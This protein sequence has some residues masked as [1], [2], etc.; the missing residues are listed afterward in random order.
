MNYINSPHLQRLYQAE[1]GLKWGLSKFLALEGLII[2]TMVAILK[3][4]SPNNTLSE[5]EYASSLERKS[6]FLRILVFGWITL[7]LLA[8]II[9]ITPPVALWDQFVL[10]GLSL[11][12]SVGI[13][14][15]NRRK[16]TQLAAT[17][18]CIITNLILI[19]VFII[20]VYRDGESV[21]TAILGCLLSLGILFAGM[22]IDLKFIFWSAAVNIG[23]VLLAFQLSTELLVEGLNRSFPIAVFLTIIALTSW[24]YQ[25]T[26]NQALG[27]LTAAR[28]AAAQAKVLQREVEIARDLQ[29]RLYP[30]PPDY[31]GRIRFAARSEPA[32][33]TGGDFYDFISLEDDHLGIVVADVSGKSFSAALVMAMARSIIR[34]GAML[35]LSPGEVLR[36]TN[37]SANQDTSVDQ[38]ITVFYGVLNTRTLRFSYSNAGHPYPMLKRDNTIK[39][40]DVPGFPIKSFPDTHYHDYS[41][42]LQPGDQLLW[43]SDGVIET[44]NQHR[45]LFGF[46]RLENTFQQTDSRDPDTILSHMWQTLVLYRNGAP[47]FDDMTIVVA[48]LEQFVTQ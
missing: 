46:E 30:P 8:L 29:Q 14:Y 44:L 19:L 24:L 4:F 16:F 5:L 17:I 37:Q 3:F 45:E 40:L 38:M 31:A 23:V 1:A 13:A 28:Q 41:I 12:T 33:D 6:S 25:K 32:E 10:I 27:R 36:Q 43:I 48:S 34:Y 20:S 26:L 2:K 39:F 9:M 18:F 21:V 42:Q 11:A 22:L 7:H 47:Q 35:S 15:L